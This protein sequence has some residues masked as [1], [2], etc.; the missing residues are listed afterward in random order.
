MPIIALFS[1]AA[2]ATGDAASS[3]GGVPALYIVGFVVAGAIVAGI[4]LWLGIHIYRKSLAKKR[5]D[6]MGP[7][8]L[9][10]RGVV[11]EDEAYEKGVYPQGTAPAGSFSRYNIN[12][13][14]ILPS[15]A[16]TKST[17]EFEQAERDQII[18]HYRQS[19]S[20]PKPFSFAL[21]PPNGP[22]APLSASGNERLSIFRSSYAASSRMSRFSVFSASS[23]NESITSTTP[24]DTGRSIRKVRQVFSPVLPD[25]LFVTLG[26][27]LMILQSFDDGWCVVGR[28][29]GILM[30]QPKSLFSG[31]ASRAAT[32]TMFG[33]TVGAG[34]GTT[35][36]GNVELGMVPAWCFLKSVKGLKAERPMRSSSLGVTVQMDAPSEERNDMISWS[37]F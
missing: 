20:F 37:N 35:S 12:S 26:E 22:P 11:K 31:R 3:K 4:A 25:E 19:G 16:L 24:G 29:S 13:Q 23:Y 27:Q 1:R 36:G 32:P 15:K 18:A 5:Q 9:S 6:R 8:F 17:P 34:V 2:P 30:P 28:E 7:A 33:H 21:Q 14:V 10:V